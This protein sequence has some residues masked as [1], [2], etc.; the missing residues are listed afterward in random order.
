MAS[1]TLEAYITMAA[2]ERAYDM[3]ESHPV[4]EF[5]IIFYLQDSWIT[6]D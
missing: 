1:R 3:T 6:R 5:K 2:S 4:Q